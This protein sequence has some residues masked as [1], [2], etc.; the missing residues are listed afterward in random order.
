MSEGKHDGSPNKE[1]KKTEYERRF[2]LGDLPQE[3]EDAIP[4][5]PY[6]DMEQGY[7]PDGTRIR[8]STDQKGN[9]SYVRA[10]KTLLGTDGIGRDEKEKLISAKQFNKLWPDTINARIYKRRYLLPLKDLGFTVEVDVFKARDV[11][12]E[13]VVEGLEGRRLAEIE[14][15]EEKDAKTFDPG[16][17]PWLGREVT[18]EVTNRRLAHGQTFPALQTP[19]IPLA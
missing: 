3:I 9:V 10:R 13:M 1:I 8:K 19:D 6:L 15:L 2:S 4:T 12:G 17:I 7:L 18:L 14:F 16:S 11:G 5:S